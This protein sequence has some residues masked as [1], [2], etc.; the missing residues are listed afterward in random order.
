M[1]AVASALLAAVTLLWPHVVQQKDF[2]NRMLAEAQR[3]VPD[4]ASINMQHVMFKS[5]DSKH[6]PY[7]ITAENIIETDVDNSIITLHNPTSSMKL[8]SGLTL[9]AKSP[10]AILLQEEKVLKMHD[11]V[12]ITADNGHKATVSELTIDE[13]DRSAESPS[14]ITL[15]GPQVSIK[16]E[17]FS[18][19]DNGDNIFLYG[20]SQVHFRDTNKDKKMSLFAHKEI[21]FDRST[22]TLTAEES[23]Q[24]RDGTNVLKADRLVIHLNEIGYY[25][26]ELK[27]LE[28]YGN[29]IVK[30]PTDIVRGDEATYDMDTAVVTGNAQIERKGGK[31]A[32]AKISIDLHTGISK[33]VSTPTQRVKGHF[34]PAMFKEN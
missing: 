20:K 22:N 25:K 13:K 18:L 32:G 7:T 2:V 24:L 12:S 9:T 28:A 17:S 26:Y 21:H 30:T 27:D 15:S 29:V 16:A 33:I 11:P 10:T 1:L 31:L 6:Q 4:K 3:N 23:T 14:P 5:E 8:N 34:I 19:Q